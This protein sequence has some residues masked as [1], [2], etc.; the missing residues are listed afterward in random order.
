MT[1]GHMVVE[2]ISLIVKVKTLEGRMRN[3]TSFFWGAVVAVLAT[4]LALT[5]IAWGVG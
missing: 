1:H 5:V 4:V 3:L 2:V